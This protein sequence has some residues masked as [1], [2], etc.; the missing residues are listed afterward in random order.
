M[1]Q[2]GF[3]IEVINIARGYVTATSVGEARQKILNGD[4]DDIVDE[5]QAGYG[6]ITD[7]WEVNE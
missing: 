1:K 4:F 5:S 6:D 7:M 2:Y 3:E